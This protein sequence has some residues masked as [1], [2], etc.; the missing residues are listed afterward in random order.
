MPDRGTGTGMAGDTYGADLSQSAI[1]RQGGMGK[2][3]KSDYCDARP[4]T[5][6]NGKI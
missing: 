5:N 2:S 3:A 6:H 4:G 1:N